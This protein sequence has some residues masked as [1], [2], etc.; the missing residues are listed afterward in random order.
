VEQE[1]DS[2]TLTRR[3]A[4]T[5]G[6]AAAAGAVGVVGLAACGGSS[7]SGGTASTSAGAGASSGSG[8]GSAALA[9][10]SEVPVGGLYATKDA[11]GAPIILSQPTA[12]TVVGFSAT[13][14]HAHCAV[15]V[16]STGKALKCPCH[17][18]TYDATGK[19]T[20]GPAPAPL[21]TVA[22]KV[23]GDKVVAG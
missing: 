1:Q 14:T 7:S 9:S 5:A 20:S 4:V 23:D 13:C 22:V 11:S 16:D 3:R 15:A 6:A 8:S 18:S 2:K 19:N 10:L 21:A 17:G 12:G